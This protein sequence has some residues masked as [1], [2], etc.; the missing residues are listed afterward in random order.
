MHLADPSVRTGRRWYPA[1]AVVE[2]VRTT[3]LTACQLSQTGYGVGNVT[4]TKR[5]ISSI[6]DQISETVG[7][8]LTAERRTIHQAA[9]WL[10]GPS[11]ILVHPPLRGCAPWS[12]F[13]F[14]RRLSSVLSNSCTFWFFSLNLQQYLP[15]GITVSMLTITECFLYNFSSKL[16]K[17]TLI[18]IKKQHTPHGLM[19]VNCNVKCTS[20]AISTV[21]VLL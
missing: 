1:P 11:P 10:G 17:K 6:R 20:D 21:T 5:N 2:D 7:E 3:C 4:C 13:S 9:F 15:S 18:N 8:S 16:W 19:V 14:I 12:K